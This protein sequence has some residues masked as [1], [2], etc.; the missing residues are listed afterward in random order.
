MQLLPALAV[1]VG[2]GFGALLRW[3]FSIAFNPI[4]PTM[5]LGTLAANIVGGFL[6]GVA[7]SFFLHNTAL[8]PEW[9][10]FAITGFLGGLTTFSTFSAEVVGLLARQQFLW[11]AGTAA[12][13]MFGSFAMTA[14]GMLAANALM[15][16]N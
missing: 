6:I 9:R 15:I 8:A 7:T 2:A 14:L 5:P 12:I 4:F 3:V 13:H 10:L 1:F 16:R 11:A